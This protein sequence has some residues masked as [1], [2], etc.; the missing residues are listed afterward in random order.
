[1]LAETARHVVDELRVEAGARRGSLGAQKEVVGEHDAV[2][3]RDRFDL[4][5]AVAVEG[6]ERQRLLGT[7][8][9]RGL[10][11]VL[12]LERTALEAGR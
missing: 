12:H 10:A 4:V 5:S 3:G 7:A 11:S 6:D 2:T 8:I 1:M 9:R